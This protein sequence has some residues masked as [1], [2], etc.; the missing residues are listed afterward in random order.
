MVGRGSWVGTQKE[1]SAGT[2]EGR[3][4]ELEG[5]KTNLF[6]MNNLVSSFDNLLKF[7]ARKSYLIPN[8]LDRS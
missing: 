3:T 1:E 5:S 7:P 2:G 4:E 8:L 6:F